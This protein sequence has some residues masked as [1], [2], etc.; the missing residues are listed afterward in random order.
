MI[1]PRCAVGRAR[2]GSLLPSAPRPGQ[3]VGD[4]LVLEQPLEVAADVVADLAVLLDAL[5]D[6]VVDLPLAGAREPRR[7]AHVP[8]VAAHSEAPVGPVEGVLGEGLRA[9]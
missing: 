9:L 6:G 3:E 4:A 1:G 7:G 8:R 5:P 2:R